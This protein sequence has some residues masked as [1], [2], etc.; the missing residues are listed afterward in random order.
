MSNKK[1]YRYL[2]IILAILAIILWSYLVKI[3]KNKEFAFLPFIP[4]ALGSY[5]LKKYKDNN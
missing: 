5:F 4:I 3:G 2:S 1:I